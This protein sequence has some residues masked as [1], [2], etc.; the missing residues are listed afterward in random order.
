MQTFA[1][2]TI[3]SFLASAFHLAESERLA[4]FGPTPFDWGAS[5]RPL[6]DAETARSLKELE[7]SISASFSSDDEFLANFYARLFP[8]EARR[9]LGE[10]YTPSALVAEVVDRAIFH[11][12]APRS[13]SPTPP[14]DAIPVFSFLAAPVPSPL[15]AQ[16]T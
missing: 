4:L 9:G 1:A 15:S 7:S 11:F 16:T 8:A 13:S 2:Q 3:F 14:G 5:I 10:F 6:L 12:A